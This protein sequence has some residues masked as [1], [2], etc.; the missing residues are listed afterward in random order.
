MGARTFQQ[1]SQFIVTVILTRVLSPDDFG[2]IAMITVFIGFAMIFSEMGISGALIQKQDITEEHL[3]SAFWLNI[4]FGVAIMGIFILCA[5]LIASFYEKPMLIPLVRVMSFSFFI[6]A[7]TVVQKALFQKK[8]NFKQLS[9]AECSSAFISG[10][11]GIICAWKGFNVWTLVIQMLVYIFLVTVILWFYSDWKPKFIYSKK[12]IR[13]I[14]HFS[15]NM[16]SFNILNYFARNVDYLLIGKFLGAEALGFYTLAYKLM[17][18]PLQYI[19]WSIESVMFPAFS[20]IQ[21]D[22]HQVGI[23]YIRMVKAI[24]FVT[25][26]MMVGLFAVAHDFVFLV[27]GSKW[28]PVAKLLQILC[29]CGLVQSIGTTVGTILKS[30]G[31]VDVQFKKQILGTLIVILSVVFGLRW[32]IYGVALCYT[33]QA[34]FWTCHM[35][36]VAIKIINLS[37]DRFY[38]SLLPASFFSLIMLIGILC[39]KLVT[40][41]SILHN[42]LLEVIFGVI[43]YVALIKYTRQVERLFKS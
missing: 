6:G 32:G 21:R 38:K 14:F 13:E 26:P 40:K 15:A 19:S 18:Y 27:Y 39:I 35:I 41:F 34:I 7:F 12:S 28:E 30:Q 20:K 29:V 11:I 37:M 42:F 25:F 17:I 1:V 23:N 5:P 33:L 43:I 8:M 9:I 3:S 4:I 10:I 24:S 36:N 2:V 31:R 16:T 22:H